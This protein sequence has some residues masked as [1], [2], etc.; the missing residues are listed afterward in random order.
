[1]Q[2]GRDWMEFFTILVWATVILQPGCKNFGG[3]TLPKPLEAIGAMVTLSRTVVLFTRIGFTLALLSSLKPRVNEQYCCYVSKIA[4][5]GLTLTKI[6][7]Y[8]NERGCSPAVACVCV[9]IHSSFV[10]AWYTY[11]LNIY[12]HADGKTCLHVYVIIRNAHVA[13]M[14][15]LVWLGLGT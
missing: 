14:S 9:C 2:I 7:R 4:G 5:T 12:I 10:Y 11:L 6:G 1:M 13:L 15:T 8:S 3:H